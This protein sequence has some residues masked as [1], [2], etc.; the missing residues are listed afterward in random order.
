MGKL[1]L[2]W[3]C[4]RLMSKLVKFWNSVLIL[5]A[6][7]QTDALLCKVA[8]TSNEGHILASICW[9]LVLFL[10]WFKIWMREKG[11]LF[12]GSLRISKRVLSHQP[13]LWGPRMPS[14]CAHIH[15]YAQAFSKLRKPDWWIYLLIIFF[16]Y[17]YA[18]VII[19]MLPELCT[20]YMPDIIRRPWKSK[21]YYWPR[22]FK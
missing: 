21:Y 8:L 19:I 4:L 20:F 22:V 3:V 9:L 13:L 11:V 7:R 5:H 16:N 18:C 2:F 15:W 6:Q 1:A 12:I 10:N 17:Q 14:G